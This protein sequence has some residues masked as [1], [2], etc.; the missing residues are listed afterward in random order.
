MK[1]Q[2]NEVKE[3]YTSKQ[4]LKFLLPSLAGAFFFMCPIP[5]QGSMVIPVTIVVKIINAILGT[6]M[7]RI[8]CFVMIV[9]GAGMTFIGTVFKPSFLTKNPVVEKTFITTWYWAAARCLGAVMTVLVYFQVGPEILIS[10][11]TGA[12]MFNLLASIFVTAIIAGGL[13]PLLVEFGLMELIGTFL[14]RIFKKLFKIP[15]RAAVDCISSWLGET[16]L[17]VVLTNQQY[18]KGYYSARE[19]CV[20]STTFSAV[21]ITFALV[22]IEQVGF[23]DMFF[24][25]YGIVCLVGIVCAIIVPRI[26]P[27]SR[28]KDTYFTESTYEGEIY[29]APGYTLPQWAVHQ[30]IH[31]ANNNGYTVKSYLT[32][33]LQNCMTIMFALP[34]MVMLVGSLSLAVAYGTDILETIGTPFMPL[35]ELLQIPEAKAASSTLIAGFADMF[36]PAILAAGTITSPFTKFL[37]AVVAMTQLI[38][39]SENGS[40]ILSTNIPVKIWELV[41]IFIERTIVSLIAASIFIRV[42]LQI[43]M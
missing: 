28:K 26:P 34:A 5:Y 43:P 4:I 41:I 12:F 32:D 39:M 8:I 27:L 17:A 19:A 35:L 31:K 14:G 29:S 13:L 7:L 30:A 9:G 18:E 2:I 40:M 16:C 42:I 15:G 10:P 22:I 24:Q 36:I 23:G 33:W 3:K 21:S 25:F 11:D 1:N 37:I 6:N 20:I 38:F